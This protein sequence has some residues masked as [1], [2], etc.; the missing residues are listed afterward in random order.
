MEGWQRT[1]PSKEAGAERKRKAP[2]SIV[3]GASTGRGIADYERNAALWLYP[4]AAAVVG[5][6]LICKKKIVLINNTLLMSSL[7]I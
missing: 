3:S 6:G 1:A 2:Q 7:T 4:C 5:P